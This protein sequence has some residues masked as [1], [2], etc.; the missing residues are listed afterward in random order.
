MIG[1]SGGSQL[2]TK[3]LLPQHP[4]LASLVVVTGGGGAPDQVPAPVAGTRL[5]WHTGAD[6]D[7]R[8]T[9]D[10]YNA[11][12]D[13][14]AGAAA[15]RAAGWD[16]T[17]SHPA[18]QAHDLGGQFGSI[19][20]AHLGEAVSAQTD[21]APVEQSWPAPTEL[22]PPA[23]APEQPEQS[24]GWWLFPVLPDL[25]DPPRGWFGLAA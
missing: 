17:E 10:G 21:T 22:T 8:G 20:A 15:Y 14:K 3:W 13:A 18:G 6:D 19:L 25:P 11:I 2:A 24:G 9:T 1:Y 7:G 5:V 16:V 23:P 12:S 4:D